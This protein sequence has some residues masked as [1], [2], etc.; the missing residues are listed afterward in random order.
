MFMAFSS[1]QIV[2]IF[3]YM[4]FRDISIMNII[5]L[6]RWLVLYLQ[7]KIPELKK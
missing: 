1:E 6:E 3:S 4:L 5:V 2:I 7:P